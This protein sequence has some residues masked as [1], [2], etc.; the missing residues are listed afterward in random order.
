[1]VSVVGIVASIPRAMISGR[2]VNA[3]ID[4]VSAI[5]PPEHPGTPAPADVGRVEFRNVSFRYRPREEADD[6]KKKKK[7]KKKKK[8]D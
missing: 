3:I 4:A 6:G 1:M 8:K 2:R 5:L 7:S